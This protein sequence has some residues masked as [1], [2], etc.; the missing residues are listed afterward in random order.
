MCGGTFVSKG[1]CGTWASQGPFCIPEGGRNEKGKAIAGL[2]AVI[3]TFCPGI[4]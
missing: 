2:D 4:G 3:G 1:L